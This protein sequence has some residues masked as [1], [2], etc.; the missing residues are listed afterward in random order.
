ME[1]TTLAVREKGVSRHNGVNWEPPSHPP[2]SSSVPQCRDVRWVLGK[3]IIGIEWCRERAVSVTAV[4]LLFCRLVALRSKRKQQGI[5]CDNIE[6]KLNNKLLLINKQSPII[7]K[8]TSAVRQ[9]GVSQHHGD[10][11][12]GPKDAEKRQ[13]LRHLHVWSLL[14]FHSIHWVF[15][16]TKIQ[17][18]N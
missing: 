12:T 2:L 15:F 17:H 16:A 10:P 5:Y 7:S 9:T 8:I 11:S 3:L 14:F 13:C 1:K 6:N 4:R 18:R